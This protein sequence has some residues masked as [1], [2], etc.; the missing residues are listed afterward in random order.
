MEWSS[1]LYLI[2][3]MVDWLDIKP[4]SPLLPVYCIVTFNMSLHHR[5]NLFST[6]KTCLTSKTKCNRNE[7]V[8]VCVQNSMSLVSWNALIPC[9]H[10]TLLVK[11][12][13]VCWVMRD[14]VRKWISSVALPGPQSMGQSKKSTKVIISLAIYY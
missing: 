5:Y 3:L 8:P 9:S 1:F 14:D 11:F 6:P 12:G 13:L 2:S 4:K 10:P 7:N